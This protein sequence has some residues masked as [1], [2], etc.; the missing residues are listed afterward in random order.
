MSIDLD[1]NPKRV[2]K[3]KKMMK[4]KIFEKLKFSSLDQ[5]FKLIYTKKA[6]KVKKISAAARL[7]AA[8]HASPCEKV[9]RFEKKVIRVKNLKIQ[10]LD[11]FNFRARTHVSKLR[12]L[13]VIICRAGYGAKHSPYTFLFWWPSAHFDGST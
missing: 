2:Q 1:L 7:A 13:I 5:I 8:A 11:V 12:Q 9:I 4:L 6:I 10:F 3:L